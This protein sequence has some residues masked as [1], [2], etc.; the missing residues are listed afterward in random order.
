MGG[1]GV[2]NQSLYTIL[3]PI[4]YITKKKIYRSYAWSSL[5]PHLLHHIYE[6]A[7]WQ[8]GNVLDSNMKNTTIVVEK[9]MLPLWVKQ[10]VV[11]R[12]DNL[13]NWVGE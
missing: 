4:D 10:N 9:S 6:S 11:I 1:R 13:G 3:S 5:L 2:L 7:N 12:E 8:R